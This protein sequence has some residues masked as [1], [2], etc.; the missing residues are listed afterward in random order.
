MKTYLII[1]DANRRNGFVY[2]THSS[3]QLALKAAGRL[4]NKL[5][6]GQRTV[7]SKQWIHIAKQSNVYY[8]DIL[9]MWVN[10]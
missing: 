3:E 9:R 8:D 5:Y 2:S 1:T 10:G 6:S 7:I 4:D